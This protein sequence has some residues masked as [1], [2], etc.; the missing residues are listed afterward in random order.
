MPFDNLPAIRTPGRANKFEKTIQQGAPSVSNITRRAMTIGLAALPLVTV[1]RASRADAEVTLKAHHFLGPNSATHAK[2]MT[3]WAERLAAATQGRLKIE[4]F[5]AM[6]LGGKPPQ[7]YDQARDGIA[8]IVWTLPGYTAGRFPLSEAIE[9][10][11]MPAQSATAISQA[12]HAF[13]EKHLL[14][15]FA[16]THPLLFS[17]HAPGS[18]HMREKEVR[19]MEDLA[20]L[21][22]R[23]PTRVISDALAAL[24]A[25]PVG[26]PV[27]Q[28]PENLSKG[29]IDGAMLP[30]E[31]AYGLKIAELTK[32]HTQ[33][34]GARGFYT[35]AFLM[36]M[37][38]AAYESLPEDLRQAIDAESGLGF[39]ATAGAIWDAAEAVGLQAALDHGN[40]VIELAPDEIERWK[41][42]TQPV[43][44]NW[45]AAATASGT[46][47]AA[48]LDDLRATIRQYAGD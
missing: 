21:K 22:L 30:F 33:L 32:S 44:D 39:A 48:L 13:A 6:Q 8:D 24:G 16:D 17:C 14:S 25:T 28:V 15:E 11:F 43:T 37:N 34:L 9:L 5:P 12:F 18:F 40:A 20:G 10:P 38:K 45:I 3:P 27:P 46:D 42:A 41:Q 4:I 47:G 31:V 2:L 19:T 35:A 26:M 7:L 29:V 36:T 1:L 23:A